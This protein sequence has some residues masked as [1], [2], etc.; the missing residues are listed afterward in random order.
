MYLKTSC[1]FQQGDIWIVELK[2]SPNADIGS[3]VFAM[4]LSLRNRFCV[5]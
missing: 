1:I 5:I 4:S 3:V 2:A